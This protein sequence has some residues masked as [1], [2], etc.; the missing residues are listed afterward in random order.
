MIYKTEDCSSMGSNANLEAREDA[1]SSSRLDQADAPPSYD[2]VTRDLAASDLPFIHP[3]PQT[4]QQQSSSNRP[5]LRPPLPFSN[6]APVSS[7]T[8]HSS[9][10]P[11]PPHSPHSPSSLPS[12]CILVPIEPNQ[13]PS[14][15]TVTFDAPSQGTQNFVVKPTY[16]PH[17]SHSPRSKTLPNKE[18][19]KRPPTHPRSASTSHIA[20]VF[21]PKKRGLFG[22]GKEKQA[23]EAREWIIANVN[24]LVRQ[25]HNYDLDACSGILGA[26][27]EACTLTS[28]LFLSD[29]LQEPFIDG[30]TPFYWS[31]IHRPARSHFIPD[32]LDALLTFGTPLTNPTRVD[33]RNAC[34]MVNDQKLFQ[35][36]RC[37]RKYMPKRM[38]EIVASD[39]HPF[40]KIRVQEFPGAEAV[41]TADFEMPMFVKRMH[42]EQEVSLEFIA[43]R[44]AWHLHFK[45]SLGSRPSSPLW[46]LSLSLSESSSPT[47]VDSQF[48]IL[49][50]A[51][52][53]P[54]RN[55][56]HP[57]PSP[58]MP[59]LLSTDSSFPNGKEKGRRM[60][61]VANT[62]RSGG[63][64]SSPVARPPVSP[65]MVRI[66]SPS[67]ITSGKKD[68]T[69]SLEDRCEIGAAVRLQKSW[70]VSHSGTLRARLEARLTK[71]EPES[72]C[73]IC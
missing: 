15:S 26:C 40:D 39:K 69:V 29:I 3:Q 17:S 70:Y 67:M 68:I 61:K 46:D 45:P 51:P 28:K 31:I 19:T 65:I 12:P 64:S 54:P 13:N 27:T 32:L 42:L 9:Y 22:V 63:T 25:T 10:I 21:V 24:D 62:Y 48:T 50:S 53:L 66:K 58:S 38:P 7:R 5:T 57:K 30:H 20:P 47:F 1:P 43:H 41:F 14:P 52:E 8:R 2:D 55:N 73:V 16:T 35:H 23:K 36:L 49:P 33:I 4:Q 6:S 34:L 60:S 11:S 56:K 44:R 72:S 59:N 37:S 71:P 18:P